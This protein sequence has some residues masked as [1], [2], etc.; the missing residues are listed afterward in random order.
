MDFRSFFMGSP[1]QF[2]QMS[3]YSPENQQQFNSVISSMLGR[4]GGNEFSFDPIEAQARRGFE[5]K[6]L[7]SIAERFS[8]MGAGA[9]RSSAFGQ[10][11]GAAGADLE[12]NLAAQR[13][14]YGLQRQ[15]LMQ[16][17]MQMGQ[18]DPFY[19]PRQSGFLENLG[20]AGVGALGSALGGY[21]GRPRFNFQ[22]PQQQMQQQP[23]QQ[24]M[25]S[26]GYVPR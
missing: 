3:R 26:P 15:G 21:L 18:Q 24:L 20:V 13:Q 22:Q 12:S 10:Q 9:G 17:L 2:G 7:P 25:Y 8:S 23:Y 11:L 16:N 19:A 6:T 4:L 1:E 5:Q 14:Q